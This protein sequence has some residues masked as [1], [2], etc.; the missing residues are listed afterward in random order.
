[1]KTST[2]NT[3]YIENISSIL[4]RASVRAYCKNW[5]D[6]RNTVML[7]KPLYTYIWALRTEPFLYII[8]A[9]RKITYICRNTRSTFYASIFI[10]DKPY[11]VYTHTIGTDQNIRHNMQYSIV[12]CSQMHTCKCKTIVFLRGWP[13][14]CSKT[15]TPLYLHHT[16]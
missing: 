15:C 7:G 3:K 8:Y 5:T 14:T 2:Q 10:F 16:V 12:S 9:F 4:M 13:E 11:V 6:L 1:M